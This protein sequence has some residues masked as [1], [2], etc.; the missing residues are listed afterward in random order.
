MRSLPCK[1][2]NLYATQDSTALKN[3]CPTHAITRPYNVVPKNMHSGRG[4]K[5][6]TDLEVD[7]RTATSAF[8]WRDLG[9]IKLGQK[10]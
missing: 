2:I 3:E 10:R 6:A 9:R 5:A 1:S 8:P 4:F 7:A